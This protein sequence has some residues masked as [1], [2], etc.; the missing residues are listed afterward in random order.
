MN[1]QIAYLELAAQVRRLG[2]V[3]DVQMGD[4]IHFG[5]NHDAIATP[6][7]V[8]TTVATLNELTLQIS[9]Q[10]TI[11]EQRIKQEADEDVLAAIV[12]NANEI[13]R[14]KSIEQRLVIEWHL[15]SELMQITDKE[16]DAPHSGLYLTAARRQDILAN[17]LGYEPERKA[18]K[19]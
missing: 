6:L 8:L 2:I 13:E 7:A 18:Y 15:Q 14:L 10:F 5:D 19:A 17:C 1:Y 4:T 9:Q 12:R 11:L 16:G 3:A